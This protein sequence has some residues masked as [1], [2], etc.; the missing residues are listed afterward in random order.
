[1]MS[2]RLRNFTICFEV[3]LHSLLLHDSGRLVLPN[4]DE[5]VSLTDG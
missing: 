1:M 3:K 4:A 5:P 2:K